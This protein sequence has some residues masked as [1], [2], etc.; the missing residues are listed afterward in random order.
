MTALR[1]LLVKEVRHI[2]RDRRTLA[3][4]LALPVVQV[5][6][7]GYAI[8]TDVS[9]V[10]LVIADPAPD[11]ATYALR[12]R[13]AGT[14][15]FR[16]VSVVSRADQADR[17]FQ[18]GEAQV[19]VVF[20]QDFAADLGAG[21]PA[22]IQVVTDATDPNTGSLLQA[23]TQSVIADHARSLGQGAAAPVIVPQ[24][25]MRFN[26]TRQSSHL[27]VP[28]LMAF[29]LTIVSAL[30]TAISLTREKETGTMEALL[31]SPLRP[32][33]IVVG[34]VAP[35]L[36]IG[37]VSVIGILIEARVVFGVPMR[38]SVALLLAEATLFILVSLSF[39]VL[40]SAR[41]SS[42]RVAMLAAM[43]TTMLP[44]ILLSG[45][46]FPVESMPAPLRLISYAVPGRWF[47]E[48]IRGVMLKGAGLGLLLGE[49]TILAAMAVFLLVASTR[50]LH[51]RLE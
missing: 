34:K 36:A 29:V 51:E 9:S 26:P 25:R 24:V 32:W 38:G 45:F 41:T 49:T 40:V 10:R 18:T 1:G 46:I 23:Y 13:L 42:Q 7:F 8:R 50:S 15:V 5:V 20:D 44:N 14:G 2:L 48:I 31:V 33:E 6:L 30:M 27:F 37:F 39:G 17:L 11:I 47:V 4:L 3:V 19:A 12:D 43:L 21:R 16:I 28:G 35:Y 22:Q